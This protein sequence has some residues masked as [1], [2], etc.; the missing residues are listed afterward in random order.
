MANIL[1]F[2]TSTT[3][4]AWD[5][6]GGWVQRLRKY[7]DQKII[8]SNHRIDYLTYNLGVSGD[9]TA[10]ILKRFVTEAE[11]RLDKY[12]GENIILFHVGI[13]DSIFN[14]KLGSTEVTN[15]EFKKNLCEL[16]N[17]ARNYSSKIVIIGSMPVD[18]RVDPMPWAKGR[19][20]KNEH[21]FEFNK[22]MDEV[23]TQEQIAFVD[24]YSE[25]IEKEY[26]SLLSDGVHMNN[27][28]HKLLYEKVRDFLLLKNIITF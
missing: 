10:D 19:S 17:L 15:E 27:E 20:Y 13:N 18:K 7:I 24:I 6:E 12:G 25:F 28:G 3:Y 23:S 11:A 22:I 4:G 5:S 14:E 9:K 21:V 1:I 26:S 16:I 8:E 2:G